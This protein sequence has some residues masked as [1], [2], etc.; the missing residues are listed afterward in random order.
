V[1]LPPPLE[2]SRYRRHMATSDAGAVLEGGIEEV[3]VKE[4]SPSFYDAKEAVWH[5]SDNHQQNLSF[6]A[7]RPTDITVRNLEVEVDV[8]ASLVNTLKAKFT[9][10]KVEDLEGSSVGTARKKKIL[11]AISADFPAGT[12][13]AI[14][15]GSGSGKVRSPPAHNRFE[16]QSDAWLRT[17]QP[18]L[19]PSPTAC[20]DQTWPSTEAPVTTDLP[21]C[22][23]LRAPMSHKLMY[24]SLL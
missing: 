13:T 12:L 14:I 4:K 21:I 10:P 11:K 20:R 3:N 7:V 8:A 22:S 2:R 17:R 6:S 16:I 19:M 18:S 15:G 1:L 5:I 24:F 9:K 23:R